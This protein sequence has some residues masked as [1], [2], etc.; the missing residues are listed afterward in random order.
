MNDDTTFLNSIIH[1]E[2]DLYQRV[3]S[4]IGWLVI[5]GLVV[6]CSRTLLSSPDAMRLVVLFGCIF[7][8]MLVPPYVIHR[9]RNR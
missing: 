6:Q 3:L 8:V 7:A 5:I 4:W 2:A 1:P 9:I